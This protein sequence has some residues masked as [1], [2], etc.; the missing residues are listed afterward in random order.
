MKL[1]LELIPFSIKLSKTDGYGISILGFTFN[2]IGRAIGFNFYNKNEPDSK[3]IMLVVYF[4]N[5]I[6]RFKIKS[7]KQ[8]H[9]ICNYCESPLWKH[10]L[11]CNKCGEDI[12]Q[13]EVTWIQTKK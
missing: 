4:Y 1:K 12:L 6:Y 7:K 13:N 5:F 10:N 9:Y 11:Y 8:D 2:N 3:N